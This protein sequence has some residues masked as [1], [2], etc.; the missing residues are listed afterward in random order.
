MATSN[1]VLS[2]EVLPALSV[3]CNVPLPQVAPQSPSSSSSPSTSSSSS[4]GSMLLAGS[5]ESQGVVL[6]L[7]ADIAA[8]SETKTRSS[9]RRRHKKR[10]HKKSCKK[11]HKK[12]SEKTEEAKDESVVERKRKRGSSTKNVTSKKQKKLSEER[13]IKRR[14]DVKGESATAPKEIIVE[15]VASTLNNDDNDHLGQEAPEQIEVEQLVEQ[16]VIEQLELD[17]VESEEMLTLLRE[18]E[19]LVDEGVV[20]PPIGQQVVDEELEEL[21]LQQFAM[22]YVHRGEDDFLTDLLSDS[23]LSSPTISRRGPVLPSFRSFLKG[24]THQ[25]HT[26]LGSSSSLALSMSLE[27]DKAAYYDEEVLLTSFDLL[28][29]E[30]DDSE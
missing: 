19:R 16:V 11:A 1:N 7:L 21:R 17:R 23:P 14:R 12:S 2:I 18:F 6:G 25:N 26:P 29:A 28:P 10:S 3:R 22:S 9:T 30:G 15:I 5:S 27:E 8:R 20:P 4:L 24:C 13:T